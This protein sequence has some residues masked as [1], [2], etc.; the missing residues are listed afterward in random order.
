M[1]GYAPYSA[2]PVARA[3]QDETIL[4]ATETIPATN[5]QFRVVTEKT[6]AQMKPWY[7]T[8]AKLIHEAQVNQA[9]NLPPGEP[10]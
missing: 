9:K 8:G 7:V 3:K 10:R 6:N 5:R 2:V 4:Y 1:G